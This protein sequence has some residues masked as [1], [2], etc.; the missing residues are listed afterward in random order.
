MRKRRD[1]DS[2]RSGLNFLENPPVGS[3]VSK[4]LHDPAATWNPAAKWSR[5]LFT[6]WRSCIMRMLPLA[7]LGV[8]ATR[9]LG[10]LYDPAYPV[11]PDTPSGV[12]DPNT[13]V[14]R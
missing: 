2:T 9:A 13:V 10:A 14:C 8:L 1:A 3:A 11:L 6:V 4:G 12:G 5:I 7:V